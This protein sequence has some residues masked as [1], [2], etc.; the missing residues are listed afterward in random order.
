MSDAVQNLIDD[1]DQLAKLRARLAEIDAERA[2]IN[3]QIN[4]TMQRIAAVVNR[5]VPPAAHT[6]L[7]H[8]IL[9]ILR[10]NRAL[11]LSPTD[12]A[13]RLGMTKNSQL[14]NIRVHLSRMRAKGWI[15]R[16][17]HGRYQAHAE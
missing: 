16:V 13:Q 9:W 17:A 11:S 6:P 2:Q 5:E 10:S 3:A 8:H 14:E 12:V 15:K 1:T 7:V 4:A